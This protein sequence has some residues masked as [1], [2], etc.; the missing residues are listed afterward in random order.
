MKSLRSFRSHKN[1]DDNKP[2]NRYKYGYNSDS[3][4]DNVSISPSK[5]SSRAW[6]LFGRSELEKIR[7]KMEMS[8]DRAIKVL[9]NNKE[10][11]EVLKTAKQACE[12]ALEYAEDNSHKVDL[13][14]LNTDDK[15][16]IE[17]LLH[18]IHDD[19]LCIDQYLSNIDRKHP[20][21]EDLIHSSEDSEVEENSQEEEDLIDSSEDEEDSDD[22]F[23]V[24]EKI[25]EIDSLLEEIQRRNAKFSAEVKKIE[26]D[27]IKSKDRRIKLE[28]VKIELPLQT[29][30][31]NKMIITATDNN[32]PTTGDENES[33]LSSC[34]ST[35]G[36]DEESDEDK[37]APLSL[38]LQDDE[39]VS[40]NV[41]LVDETRVVFLVD[42]D[43]ESN[44]GS[45]DKKIKFVDKIKVQDAAVKVVRPSLFK[46][47]SSVLVE[48][49]E[50][51]DQE[52]DQ[53]DDSKDH[54]G[55]IGAEET[56][57]QKQ[58]LTEDGFKEKKIDKM[59][60]QFVVNSNGKETKK[61]QD[62]DDAKSPDDK[63]TP[64]ESTR[65]IKEKMNVE[66]KKSSLERQEDERKK[67]IG[68]AAKTSYSHLILTLSLTE[69]SEG[70][71]FTTLS[72]N[73]LS[74]SKFMLQAKLRL[75]LVYDRGK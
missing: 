41:R 54:S 55:E 71:L 69:I 30:N 73:L 52:E 57:T 13:A 53:A 58:T 64:K 61:D 31:Q 2:D 8:H 48:H 39:E 21:V 29:T 74:G 7:D 32:S 12:K 68:Q 65:R 6:S 36:K 40:V 16:E 59:K 19:V 20:E 35:R 72:T 75:Q 56:P 45:D 62:I 15:E 24:E 5:H 17:Q 3:G 42:K 10:D 11:R 50:E 37:T 26:D 51:A 28:K 70:R 9:K 49:K 25:K 47:N 60:E 1:V 63:L 4:D 34:S 38:P 66:T 67:I 43:N 18:S 46:T 14:E 27:L 23:K 22:S 44:E 33:N